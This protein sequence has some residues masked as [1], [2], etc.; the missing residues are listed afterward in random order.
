MRR[1]FALALLLLAACKPSFDE[2][3]DKAEKNIRAE[4]S[5]VDSELAAK[6]QATPSST[7][8][9]AQPSPTSSATQEA[10]SR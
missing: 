7:P 9:S 6:Q 1:A 8:A 3:Y 10:R 5:G 2:R 4:A